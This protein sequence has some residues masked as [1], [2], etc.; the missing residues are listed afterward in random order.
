[1]S[2][3]LLVETIARSQEW[4]KDA[5]YPVAL[6]SI[7]IDFDKREK[8]DNAFDCINSNAINDFFI[9][10]VQRQAIKLY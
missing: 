2:Y 10:R 1:M 5:V 4:I 7:V 9:A 6:T 3:K 8:A